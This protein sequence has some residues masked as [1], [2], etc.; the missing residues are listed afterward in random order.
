MRKRGSVNKKRKPQY[1]EPEYI[2][3][4]HQD[5]VFA[6]IK[7]GEPLF[8]YDLNEAKPLRGQGKFETL[9]HFCYQPIQQLFI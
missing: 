1:T 9:I 4:D 7:G 5:R 3:I 6:G 8:S 2:V